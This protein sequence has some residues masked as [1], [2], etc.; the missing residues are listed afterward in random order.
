M[1]SAQLRSMLG[2]GGSYQGSYS[3]H[4]WGMN[5][6]DWGEIPSEGEGSIDCGTEGTQ[7]WY[8]GMEVTLQGPGVE[9]T[10]SVTGNCDVMPA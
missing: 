4:N 1:S 5:C 3:P 7:D 2:L 10:C 8:N 9:I 6:G